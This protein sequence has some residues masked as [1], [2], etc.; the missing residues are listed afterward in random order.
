[1][2]WILPLAAAA[3]LLG[4]SVFYS[5]HFPG[6]LPAYVSVEI[7]KDGSAVYKEAPDDDNPVGFKMPDAETQEVF[8]LAEKLERF[9]RPLESGLKVARMGDK[10]FR[11]INGEEKNEVKFN[12]SL[13]EDAKLLLDLFER[14]TETQQLLFMLERSV[15]F[16]KLGVNQALLQVEAAWDR[17]RIVGPERFLPLLD[18][19]S[20]NGSYLNMARER[21]GALAA[22]FRNPPPKNAATEQK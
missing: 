17:K 14:M 7:S 3:P 12:F 6:S 5:K 19:V 22:A 10:T 9:K 11:F 1:M 20:K 2:N 13:D 18:R 16:D 21:S 15:K 8:A 4:Q